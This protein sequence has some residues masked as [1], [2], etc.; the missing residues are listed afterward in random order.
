[1]KNHPAQRPKIKLVFQPGKTVTKVVLMVAI[2]ASI[3]ALV[4]IYGAINQVQAQKE[5]ARSEAAKL[6]QSNAEL[7]QDIE[8]LGTTDSIID[9]ALQMLG[10]VPKDTVIYESGN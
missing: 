4:A 2:V 9:I 5:F 3:V 7:E 1:M 6:E 10:L 8:Q